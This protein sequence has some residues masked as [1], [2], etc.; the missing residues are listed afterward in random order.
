MNL[1]CF[2]AELFW[3]YLQDKTTRSAAASA[4]T[5]DGNETSGLLAFLDLMRG[6]HSC[7]ASSAGIERWFSTI[8]FVWSYVWNRLGAE[9]AKK[10]SFCYRLL[11]E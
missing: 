2:T 11:R 6:L 3:N 1:N 9:T 8:G 5:G 10:L 4:P 7:P